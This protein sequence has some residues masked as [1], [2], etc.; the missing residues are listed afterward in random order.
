MR[1]IVVLG[2]TGSIGEQ[3]LR[4]ADE[5]PDKLRVVGIAAN[6]NVTRLQ[7]Q[8]E[9]LAPRYAAVADEGVMAPPNIG[10][11][12]DA[13]EEMVAAP[14]VDL[15]VVAIVGSA[16][17]RPTLA[18]LK[19]GKL[20]ALANKETLVMAGTLIRDQLR[21]CGE[22]V[23]I[24][25]EHSAIWQCLQGEPHAAIEKLVLTASGGAFRDLDPGQLMTVTPHQALLHPTW[26]MGPKVTIDSATL[27]NKG[28][29]VIEATLLFDVR[30]DDVEVVMH[31]ES[32]VHSMV[33]F[34]DGSVKA[35]LGLPDMRLPI[36]YALTHPDRWRNGLERLDLAKIG[37]LN[38]GPVNWN[39]Y[40]CL[41]LAIEAGKN[42]GTYPAALC[43]A[44]EVAVA[45]FLQG[46][47]PFTAVS[48]VVEDTLSKHDQ[49][50]NPTFDDILDA[51]TAARR[52]AGRV[53]GELLGH[54]R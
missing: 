6:R 11:G 41:R 51:D 29:E 37:S 32:I 4:I 22:L 43:A 1:N 28:L 25:S 40:P 17:L 36:Q 21:R 48:N 5:F 18:A 10:Q 47:I 45:H 27:M 13:L 50:V 53:A 2:S 46:K 38:F 33:Y 9:Q 20:V 12:G 31:R 39:R 52:D 26:R 23:P 7:Q 14:D 44:D 49:C 3:T 35:Q 42:G 8:V 15:V 19:A 54:G 30:M 34:G 16:G 24:D